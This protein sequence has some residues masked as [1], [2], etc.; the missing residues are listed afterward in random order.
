MENEYFEQDTNTKRVN[1]KEFFGVYLHG[2]ETFNLYDSAKKVA[3]F[4]TEDA[5]RLPE[6]VSAA[7]LRT[8]LNWF[9]SENKIHLIHGATIG[10]DDK[11]VLLSAKGGSGKSTTALSCLLS[12]MDYLADD[13]IG[14]KFG[15]SIL[16]LNLYNSVKIVPEQMEIFPELKEK[17]W[18]T[19]SFRGQVDK[20]KAIVFLGEILP[21][22]IKKVM[23][24]TAI[25]IPR[26]R[27]S[28]RIVP[29]SRLEAMLALVPTTLF[30]LPLVNSNKIEELKEIIEKLPCYFLELG[31]EIR[32]IPNVIKDFI[33]NQNSI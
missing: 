4:F 12:G 30:Q 2:E 21:K 33:K 22:Q 26:I 5:E 23:P 11:A 17:I 31:P 24:L 18:N 19:E 7:P 8:I 14:V 3:Y 13:Y 10:T 15:E 27:K 29:A 6:W 32:E 28:T 20:G 25:L 1:Q 9:L 16:A